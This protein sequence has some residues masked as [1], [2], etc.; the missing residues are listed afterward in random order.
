[1]LIYGETFLSK[2]DS[3]IK[4]FNTNKNKS[5]DSEEIKELISKE[6]FLTTIYE[7]DMTEVNEIKKEIKNFVV[8]KAKN[9]E[10]N[11]NILSNITN[12]NLIKTG[13]TKDEISE[14][15]KIED[16]KPKHV[17][18]EKISTSEIKQIS[19]TTVFSST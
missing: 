12:K 7:N 18:K 10:Q 5:S 9:K 13:K 11:K 6:D 16:Q 4:K 8:I 2:I 3:S 17:E 14:T 1:L 15:E 19:Y